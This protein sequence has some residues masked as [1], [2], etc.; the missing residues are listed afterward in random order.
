VEKRGRIIAFFINIPDPS[1]IMKISESG[2][3]L[4][5]GTVLTQYSAHNAVGGSYFRDGGK[6]SDEYKNIYAL[7]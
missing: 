7:F 2:S 6:T 1:K 5:K 3:S 4:I